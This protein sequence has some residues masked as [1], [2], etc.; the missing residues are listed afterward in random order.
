MNKRA[1]MTKGPHK[2][3]RV[4]YTVKI[5]REDL[6][7]AYDEQEAMDVI[8]EEECFLTKDNKIKDIKFNTVKFEKEGVN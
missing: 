4:N 3:F 5:Q 1:W 6:I 2:V 8:E 7:K